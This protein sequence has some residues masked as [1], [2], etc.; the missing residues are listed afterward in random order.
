VAIQLWLFVLF[1]FY[2]V[3]YELIRALGKDRVRKMFCG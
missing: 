1:L 2:A 3:L